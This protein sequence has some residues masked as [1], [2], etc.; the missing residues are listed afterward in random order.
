MIRIIIILFLLYLAY[1][2]LKLF[3]ARGI[4]P[5]SPASKGISAGE[6]VACRRCGTYILK[7]EA[8]KDGNDFYCSAEC[9]NKP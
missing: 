4:R 5:S 3:F 9:K 2:I 1:R 7:A 6:M 8:L